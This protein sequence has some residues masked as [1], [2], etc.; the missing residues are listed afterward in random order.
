[1]NRA[2]IAGGPLVCVKWPWHDCSSRVAR[3]LTAGENFDCLLMAP[4]SQVGRVLDRQSSSEVGEVS[5]FGLVARLCASV[6][7][8]LRGFEDLAGWPQGGAGAP[9]PWQAQG[10]WTRVAQAQ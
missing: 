5:R 1:M 9:C 8:S 2:V 4:S 6:V 7:P 3:S 10:F